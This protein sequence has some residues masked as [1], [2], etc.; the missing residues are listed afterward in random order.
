[1]S[2][3][4]ERLRVNGRRGFETEDQAAA[5]RAEERRQ[6]ADALDACER[7]LRTEL[8]ALIAFITPYARDENGGIVDPAIAEPRRRVLAIR[9]A[10]AK[11]EASR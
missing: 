11:L 9:E 10:L 3:L 5:R 7:A 6:A 4:A 8:D 1:M 2:K